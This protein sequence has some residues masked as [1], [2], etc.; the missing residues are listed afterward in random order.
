M[1]APQWIEN[2]YELLDA[3]GEWYL[4]RSA[5]NLYYKPLPGEN[6]AS[7]EIIAPVLEMLV[8]GAGTVA[9]PLHDAAFQGI[10]FSHATWLSPSSDSGY[11]DVQATYM[12]PSSGWPVASKAPANVVFT[13]ARNIRIER[14]VFTR[15]GG[16][17]LSF[18][19]GCQR[20]LVIGN[21]FKDI[22]ANGIHIGNVDPSPASGEEVAHITVKDNYVTQTGAEYQDAVG[23]FAGYTDSAVIIHNEILNLPYTGI[24]VGWGW[25]NGVHTGKNNKICYNLIRN[26]MQVL[27]D[28]G[29]IYTL[30]DQQN[31]EVSYNFVDHLGSNN[32]LYPDEG[33]SNMHWPIMSCARFPSGSKCG[34]GPFRMTLSTIITTTARTR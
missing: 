10:T 33:S 28:G 13:A 32:A 19:T 8:N 12:W 4:D 30:S 2:A 14:C 16:A 11:P 34:L 9:T 6:M 27:I 21:F 15:L 20:D 25:N 29:G 23:I 3:P 18:E 17:G 1:N 24:S 7:V 26:V 31:T 22:S 5:G